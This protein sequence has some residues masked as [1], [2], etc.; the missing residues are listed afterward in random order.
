[1]F[2]KKKC[3]NCGEKINNKYN[4]CP[5]CR[6]RLN[7][8]EPDDDWGILGKNDLTPLD[9]FMTHPG[10]SNLFNS[11]VKN[12]SKEIMELERTDK[13]QNKLGAGKR[14]AEFPLFSSQARKKGIGISIYTSGN[15]TPKIMLSPLGENKKEIRKKI[16]QNSKIFEQTTEKFIGLPK[17]EAETNIRRLSKKIIYEIY[18]PDVKSLKDISI[19][20]LENSIEIKALG[21]NRVFYKIV[22]VNLPIK[23]YNLSKE[24]L[25]L[26]F[27]AEE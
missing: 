11:L 21:K 16:S 10:F 5:Y 26:E 12:L 23:K 6:M 14:N 2:G 24:K 7:D 17:E 4:F 25:V 18:L 20:Q 22:P 19:A 15:M 1:M 3:K 9:G 13:K 8:A 27:D